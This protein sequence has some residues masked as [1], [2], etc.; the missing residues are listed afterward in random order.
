MHR[1]KTDQ[2][3]LTFHVNKMR[4]QDI[5]G[6]PIDINSQIESDIDS[7]L[8]EEVEEKFDKWSATNPETPLKLD[9]AKN[10]SDIMNVVGFFYKN[11]IKHSQIYNLFSNFGNISMIMILKK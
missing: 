11:P 7:L 6:F 9:K 4:T 8:H 2:K 5:W 1:S 10:S 3:D